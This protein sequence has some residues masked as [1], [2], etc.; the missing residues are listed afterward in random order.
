RPEIL[1]LA[2][3]HGEGGRLHRFAV[4]LRQA[5]VLP[6]A[7]AV[8]RLPV[9]FVGHGLRDALFCL[10]RLGLPEAA[11]LWDTRVRERAATLDRS[12]RRYRLAP[13]ADEVA[14]TRAA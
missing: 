12:H 4:D 5:D 11:I 10:F 9:C 7:S 3:V 2:Q 6:A 14:Q 8:L 1:G 13:R